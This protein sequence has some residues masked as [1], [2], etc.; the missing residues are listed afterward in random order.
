MADETF[1]ADKISPAEARNFA[2]VLD[3]LRR[4]ENLSACSN[5]EKFFTAGVSCLA[6]KILAD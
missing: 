6:R 4:P 1:A 2:E 3:A 5:I